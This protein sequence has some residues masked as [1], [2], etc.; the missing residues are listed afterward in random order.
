MDQPSFAI[1]TPSYAP[2]F[3][4]CKLLSWSIQEFISP[5]VTHYIIVDQQDL[6]LFRQ[7]VGPNTEIITKESILPW[8]IKQLP[9][10]QSKNIW[11]SLKSMPVRGWLIQQIIKI[12]IAQHITEDVLVFADSDVAFIRPFDLR[13][14]VR[15]DQVR[16]FR[17]SPYKQPNSQWDVSA[18]RLLGLSLSNFSEDSPKPNYVGQLISW[19][20]ENVLK[21]YRHLESISGR[22]WIETLC[23][24]WNLSEYELYGIF[25]DQVLKDQAEHYPDNQGFCHCHWSPMSMESGQLQDFFAKITHE[26][27]A[28]MI[29]AKAGI[30]VSRY[31]HLVKRMAE[32]SSSSANI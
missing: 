31:E 24:S 20:H 16:L 19:K 30:A 1:I 26:N 21:L 27:V 8:W 29:T 15:D 12:G 25:I 18:N 14:F 2:D 10:G 3:E 28:V 9:F 17:T 11:L 32:E 13:S 7:L 23:R 5:P 22:S 6:K 4:R